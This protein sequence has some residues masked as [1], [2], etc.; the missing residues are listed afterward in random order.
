[1]TDL[2]DIIIVWDFP[3]PGGALYN[4][5][6]SLQNINDCAMLGRVCVRY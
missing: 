4:N 1:M 5:V 6:G 2:E 3:V